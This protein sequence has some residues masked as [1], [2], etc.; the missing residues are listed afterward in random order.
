M[1]QTTFERRG[2]PTRTVT[3]S[4][5]SSG[6]PVTPT[7]SPR[8]TGRTESAGTEEPTTRARRRQ[9]DCRGPTRRLVRAHRQRRVRAHFRWRATPG[10]LKWPAA[11]F[12]SYR[13][14]AAPFVVGLPGPPSLVPPRRLQGRSVPPSLVLGPVLP[15]LRDA[16]RAAF[17]AP[18][19][20]HSR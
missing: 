12:A 5:W 18:G 15:S 2:S 14:S 7:A 10:T 9:R 1:A 3:G 20:R 11:V 6:R 16:L 17:P 19:P 13:R 8:P 4:S